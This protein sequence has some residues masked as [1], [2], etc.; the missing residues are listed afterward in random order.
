MTCAL[1]IS[2]EDQAGSAS[3]DSPVISDTEMPFGGLKASGYGHENDR[4]A[5]SVYTKLKPVYFNRKFGKRF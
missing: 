1:R 2:S 4:A 3:I 5:I